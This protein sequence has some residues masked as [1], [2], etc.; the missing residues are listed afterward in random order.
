MGVEGHVPQL[1]RVTTLAEASVLVAT[2]KWAQPDHWGIGRDHT[3]S[4]ALSFDRDVSES[5]ERD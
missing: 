2:S 3:P 4:R 5:V 1:C